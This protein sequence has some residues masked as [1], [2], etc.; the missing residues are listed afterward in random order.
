MARLPATDLSGTVIGDDLAP[1]LEEHRQAMARRKAAALERLAADAG[2]PA[3][4]RADADAYADAVRSG[5]KDPGPKHLAALEAKAA[6]AARRVQGEDAIIA[7]VEADITALRTKRGEAWVQDLQ[8][9]RSAI[10]ARATEQADALQ[11]AMTDLWSVESG[12]AWT[13]TGRSRALGHDALISAL[14]SV[15]AMGAQAVQYVEE[16]DDADGE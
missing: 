1:L 10:L 8:G 9:H 5:G 14:A 4:R 3:A 11:A 12:I 6:D 13:Q 7:R 2:V 16:R 15:R